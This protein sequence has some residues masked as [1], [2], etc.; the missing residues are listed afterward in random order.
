MQLYTF[1]TSTVLPDGRVARQQHDVMAATR[2]EAE[3]L[4]VAVGILAG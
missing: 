3:A 2:A 1:T 4:L